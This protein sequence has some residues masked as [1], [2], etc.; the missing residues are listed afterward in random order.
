MKKFFIKGFTL[1]LSFLPLSVLRW[2]GGVVGVVAIQLSHRAHNRIKKNLLATGMCDE[3]NVERVAKKTSVEWGKTL[4]EAACIAWRRSSA[5]NAK[6]IVK[7]HGFTYMKECLLSGKPTV[8]LTPHIGNFEVALKYTAHKLSSRVFTILYKP[9]KA[10]WLNQVMLEGRTEKNIKPVPT[11]RNGM[12]TLI[13]DLR[14]NGI[15]G[16]LPDSIASSGDGV[17]VDFFGQKTFATTLAAK[18]TLTENA[19]T[20]IVASYRVKGG[21][22]VDYIPF[23]PKSQHVG[24][25]VQDIYRVI[26][27]IIL[28][29]PEQYYWSYDRF[30]VP[31]HAPS[32]G[33]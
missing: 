3:S 21:F 12:F 1:C 5:Y 25:V 27:E 14:A 7:A 24:V 11:N 19:H 8:F 16:V 29:A 10:K 31:P 20:F 4:I 28:K 2:L 17:W 13:K 23:S 15:V 9:A 32:I 33:G 6:L 22:E 26:E 18:M 30:R